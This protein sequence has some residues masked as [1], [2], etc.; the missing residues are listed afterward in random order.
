MGQYGCELDCTNADTCEGA[1]IVCDQGPC[2]LT[3]GPMACQNT[4]IEC[5]SNLCTATYYAPP[6][7]GM[8]PIAATNCGGTCTGSCTITNMN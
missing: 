6:D 4:T 7:A 5:S 1:K 2:T 3:C 8:L